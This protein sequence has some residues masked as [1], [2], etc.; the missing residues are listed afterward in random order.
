MWVKKS[1]ILATMLLVTN[2][3]A[4]SDWNYKVPEKWSNVNVK[5]QACSGLN[6]SPID[7]R[8]TIEAELPPLKFNYK[9]SAKS[10]TNKGH[11]IQVDFKSGATLALDN[12][13]FELK[14]L[15]VHSPSENTILGKSYPM[16]LHLVHATEQGELAVVALMF[17]SGKDNSKLQHIWA[18][19]PKKI[20]ETRTFDSKDQA[21]DFLPKN[22]DYYRFNG[23]LTTPPCTEGVRWLVMKEIQQASPTQIKAFADLMAEPNNR[24]VQPIGSR[25][26]LE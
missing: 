2:V 17:E 1:L 24:P 11:T 16:E 7:I 25:I 21:A 9:T 19:L 18:L 3:W 5:Y 10:I 14:Q 4:D 22:L 12:K 6:Q 23:S 20:G 13:I 15:H 8:N 26:I